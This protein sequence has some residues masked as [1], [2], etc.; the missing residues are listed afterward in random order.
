MQVLCVHPPT[1][2]EDKLDLKMKIWSEEFPFEDHGSAVCWPVPCVVPAAAGTFR[3]L[4][5]SKCCLRSSPACLDCSP[6]WRFLIWKWCPGTALVTCWSSMGAWEV[7]EV[8]SEDQN[9]P[10]KYQGFL[11]VGKIFTLL[12]LSLGKSLFL[13]VSGDEHQVLHTRA[14]F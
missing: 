4:F 1:V 7:P 3:L 12:S 10:S 14:L 13:D 9:I 11:L 6:H 2:K 8:N 5:Y